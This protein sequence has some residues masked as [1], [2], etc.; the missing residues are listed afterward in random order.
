MRAKFPAR[1][2]RVLMTN[3]V[4]DA[5]AKLSQRAACQS[6]ARTFRRCG[7]SVQ[8]DGSEDEDI[9]IRGLRNYK[10]YGKMLWQID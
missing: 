7:I 10:V 4:A 6:T 1:Q 8:I 5:Y 9:E 3:W 2:R